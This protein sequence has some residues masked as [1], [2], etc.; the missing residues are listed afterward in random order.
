MT[1]RFL[2][3]EYFLLCILFPLFA[4]LRLRLAGRGESS[5]LF[6]AV[7][8][9]D[10]C[11]KTLRQRFSFIPVLL[12]FTAALFIVAGLAQP[13]RI[14][15]QNRRTTR[16]IAIELVV[17]RSSSMSQEMVYKDRIMPKIDIAREVLNSFVFGNGNGNGEDGRISDLVGLVTFARYGETVYPLSL[18]HQTLRMFLD[19]LAIVREESED[20]TSIG[21]ALA[22]AAA[23]LYDI[24]M[25]GTAGYEIKSRIIILLTDGINNAGKRTP[26]EGAETA[27]E[28]GVK[29][30]AIGFAGE[31]TYA[32]VSTPFGDQ[33][34]LIPGRIDE[35][36]LREAAEITG[37]EF[38][39]AGS[40]DALEE[41][42]REIDTLEKSEVETIEYSRTEELY[43]WCTL[44]ALFFLV[45]EIASASFIFRK[46][47]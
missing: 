1:I 8:E 21:D 41:I 30:Y 22:L 17:D 23:R 24:E 46:V 34:M 12:R 35:S 39:I 37:G 47:P 6:P 5:V 7:D 20:G 4:F 9:L 3:P 43:L 18:G 26:A 13:Q 42:Y 11:P 10:T 27:A 2:H 44:P 19:S 40:G 31:E 29:I 16:G 32:T 15:E 33:K 14:L 38:R 25:N 28:Y 36:A 45:M